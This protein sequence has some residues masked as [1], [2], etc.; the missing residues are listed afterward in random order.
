MKP[1]KPYP[2]FPLFPHASGKWAKKVSGKIIYFGRWDNPAGALAEYERFAGARIDTV[3]QAAMCLADACN[4]FL[5][6][7]EEDKDQGKLS[8]RT[9]EDYKSMCKRLLAFLGRE[10]DMAELQPEDFAAYRRTRE[11]KCNLVSVG[12]EITRVRTLFKWLYDSRLLAKPMHFGPDFRQPQA[13]A[14]RR[15]RRMKGKK[16]FTADEILRILDEMGLHMRAMTLLGINCGFGPTDCATLP[17]NAAELANGWL[18]YPRPKTEV[19]RT[20]P[21]WPET[22]QALKDSLARRPAPQAG[23]ESLFFLLPDG[24]SWSNENNTIQRRFKAALNAAGIK[25][26]SHY[27]LRHTFET[28]AGGSKDQVAV[29]AIMGHA[30]ASMAAVYREEIGEDRLLAVVEYVRA[31]LFGR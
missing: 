30:D 17:I 23:N 15:H 8:S 1:A 19:E 13:K 29:S 25:H 22:L 24:G 11:E 6:S 28:I 31:W 21:L 20:V 12:N 14:V 27:W 9:Y 2:D 3:S 7:K 16:L 18:T 10:R 26:G 4:L 5:T